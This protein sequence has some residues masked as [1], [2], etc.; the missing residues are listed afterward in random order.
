MELPVAHCPIDSALCKVKGR[1][2]TG[3][4]ARR[5]TRSRT[6]QA[7]RAPAH[8]RARRM[9]VSSGMWRGPGW[10]TVR[11]RPGVRQGRPRLDRPHH[12]RSPLPGRCTR[13]RPWWSASCSA[14]R[15]CTARTAARAGR[16]PAVARRRPDHRLRQRRSHPAAAARRRRTARRR[17]PTRSGGLPEG[18]VHPA[19]PRDPTTCPKGAVACWWSMRWPPA[20]AAS[21]PHPPRWCGATSASRCPRRP[22][23]PGPG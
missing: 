1:A 6:T 2:M 13:T 17:R 18:G 16:L 20:G 7:G 4:R 8:A 15:S 21:A 14:T 19:P 22:L 12:R 5:D 3:G 9:L 10:R 11:G 23:R